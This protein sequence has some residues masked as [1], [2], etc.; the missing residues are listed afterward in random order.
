MVSIPNLASTSTQNTPRAENTEVVNNTFLQMMPTIQTHASVQ[1]RHL[2][3]I[4]REEAVAETVAGAYC[5][6][7]SAIRRGKSDGVTA[8]TLASFGA[9][10]VKDHRHVGTGREKATD[11]LH[12]RA[13]RLGGFRVLALPWDDVRLD[14]LKES[15]PAVWRL[16]L[17]H[18]RKTP[19]PD[20]AAFRLDWARFLSQQT[21]RTR[22]A[23]SL[24]AAGHKRYEV[25]DQLGCTPS[26]LCQRI[27]GVRRQWQSLQGE[28][29]TAGEARPCARR[30]MGLGERPRPAA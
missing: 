8:S 5:D 19:V 11:P 9:L 14:C 4:E 29:Q 15:N 13:Q 16:N 7:R 30:S 26:A 18:D 10:H 6:F 3:P 27:A 12:P 21:D 23:M 1:F 28:S 17:L 24:L 22:I 2:P 25:A 20:Q